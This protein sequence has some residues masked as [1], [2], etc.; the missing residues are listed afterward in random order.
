MK[1]VFG[2]AS[3]RDEHGE[4]MHKSKGNAIWFDDAV[5]KIGADPMRWMYSRQNPVNDLKFGYKSAEEIKRKLLT[6]YNVY[7]FFNTYID[8][9]DF[10]KKELKSNNA[11]DQWIVSRLNNVIEK[12]TK[13]L[14]SYNIASAVLAIEDFFIQDLSL[15]YVRRS[16]KRFKQGAEK[17]EQAISTLYYVLL[18][19]LKLIAPAMPFFAEEMYNKLKAGNMPESVHLCDWPKS[20]KIDNKLEEKMV[21]VRDIVTLVLAERAE[22]GI[23]VRQPLA[24]LTIKN[25]LDKDLLELIK[26]EVNVKEIDFGKKIKLDTKITKE[27]KKEGEYREMVRNVN[28][29]RKEMGLTPKDFVVI[30]STFDVINTEDFKKE[31]GAKKFNVK[32]EVAGKEIKINNQT[33]YI[34][35]K[36]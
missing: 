35:I 28:K 15:W 32:K 6:L 25:K 26:E 3:V 18:N 30:D 19:L 36:K 5:E 9:K 8:K 10:P 12:A 14:D 4:E 23:K 16:R 13:S 31:V 17:K 20:G 2:H 21:Q 7:T 1:T 24:R 34:L 27:L 22:A 11:L 33:H 29:I